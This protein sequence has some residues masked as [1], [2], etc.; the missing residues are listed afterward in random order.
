[1]KILTNIHESAENYESLQI[2][3]DIQTLSQS[4]VEISFLERTYAPCFQRQ[5]RNLY[6]SDQ[7]LFVGLY[8]LSSITFV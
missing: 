8:Y 1:M 6:Y 3:I 2:S 4:F 5:T 7:L